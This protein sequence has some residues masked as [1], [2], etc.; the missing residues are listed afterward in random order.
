VSASVTEH[1]ADALREHAT[2]EPVHP[3]NGDVCLKSHTNAF[4]P[5]GPNMQ[6][7][8]SIP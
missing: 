5:V 7:P 1:V 8:S 6:D 4:H 3:L 2:G